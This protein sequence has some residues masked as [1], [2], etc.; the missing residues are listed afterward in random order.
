MCV[1][2]GG[3]KIRSHADLISLVLIGGKTLVSFNFLE[4]LRDFL[5]CYVKF[6]NLDIKQKI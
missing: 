6:I 3:G 1:C 4:L 5:Y 2:V